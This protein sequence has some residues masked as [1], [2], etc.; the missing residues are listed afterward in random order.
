MGLLQIDT[1]A[2]TVKGQAQGYMTGI[3]YL[4]PH[5]IAGIGNLCPNA[6]AGCMA[7]CL[8]KAGRGVFNAVQ[9]ARIRKAQ[10][11]K[12]DR[13]AFMAA[14]VK[15]IAALVRKARKAGMI[16]VVRLNGTSDLPWENIS[17]QTEWRDGD[18][19]KVRTLP[20]IMAAFPDVQFYDYTK[21][22]R[23]MLAFCR[24]ELPANYHL[25]F[26]RSER[27]DDDC[28]KVLEAGGNVAVVFDTKRGEALPRF[29]GAY[30]VID[31]DTS[32]LRFADPSPRN[33]MFRLVG[34]GDRGVIVGLRAKGPA[35]KDCH[36]FVVKA[37]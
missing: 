16:P 13:A 4:A 28:A 37:Q 3:L 33:P 24:G 31:G 23:R 14:L 32:D 34:R 18:D 6:S 21:S 5:T 30:P 19:I 15:D 10:A 7:G 11:F 2:K 25:T 22:A 20:N 35:R 17:L 12:A 36:G 1:N 27:N 29:F 26:S 8:Y 9:T